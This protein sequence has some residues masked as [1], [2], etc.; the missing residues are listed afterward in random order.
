LNRQVAGHLSQVQSPLITARLARDAASTDALFENLRN[1]YYIRDDPALTQSLGWTDA[2]TSQPSAY[3][4]EA[5]SAREVAA[6]VLF[7][8]AHNLRLVVKGGGH[9][10]IGASNA[11]DSLLIWTRKMD[12][13]VMHDAFVGVGAMESTLPVPAVS[14][15][16]G[17]IWG[18]AYDAVTTRGG[19]YVQG[20][21]CLTV[22]VAGFVLGGGFGSFSK[23]Y[24]TGASNL[25]EAEVVT[26]DGRILIANDHQH[27]DLLWALKGGGG[28]TFG[29]VTR[30]TMRTHDLPSTLGVVMLDVQ[31]KSRGAWRHLVERMI[32]FYAA[33]LF[34]PDWGEQ[35][36]FNQRRL[37]VR[38]LF[39]GLTTEQA[40]ANWRPFID[41]V[42]SNDTDFE[43]HEPMIAAFPARQMWDPAFL[44]TLPGIILKDNRPG[45]REGDAYWAQN[46]AE[47]G[48]VISG[49]HSSWLPS[50]LLGAGAREAL[51]SALV[52]ASER[53]GV[54]LHFNKGIA[55]GEPHARAACSATATNPR[56]VDAFALAIVAGGQA[57]AYPGVSGHEPDVAAGRRDA[58]L[59]RQAFAPLEAI[60]G[61]PASYVS[62]TDYFHRHWQEAFWGENYPRLLAIKRRYDPSGLFKVHHGVGS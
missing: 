3:A 23:R 29:I 25:L 14:V 32:S 21:G 12:S 38:M 5:T 16:A 62:E 58:G 50:S 35:V 34:N 43:M 33:S 7:A 41:Y 13:V 57:P 4:I 31:A 20:G 6:G 17:A 22:G 2:W 53:W 39:A 42:R 11:P 36:G 45:A 61:P 48:W 9:S 30:V 59:M 51:V 60:S 15:G 52:E 37:T 54:D 40:Q 27:Q 28:G 46:L 49:Y 47:T 24:G 18:R 56:M 19:R 10:Y 1:P 55:G 26:A 44:G 8:R